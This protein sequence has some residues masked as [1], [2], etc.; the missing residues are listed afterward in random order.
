[1]NLRQLEVYYAIMRCRTLTDA[2]R[3]LNVSQPA[4]SKTLSHAE[5]QLGFK[6]FERVKGRLYPTL[7][8][9]T[10]MPEAERIFREL[11]T[12]RQ[13]S[14]DL[15][16]G[17][18]GLVRVA[19]TSSLGLTIMPDAIAAFRRDHPNVK[20]V[21]HVLPAMR[22][23]ELILS[24]KIDIGITM[25][26]VR[27][28]TARIERRGSVEMVCI[29]PAG[30]PLSALER[31]EPANL[32]GQSFVCFPAGEHFRERIDETLKS[33]GIV[34][35]FDLEVGYSIAAY[36]LVQRGMG[37]ALVDG[38]LVTMPLPG[39]VWRPFRPLIRAEVHVVTASRMPRSSYANRFR[40]YL[41]REIERAVGDA[42]T[43]MKADR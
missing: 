18:A 17:Q 16:S 9:E 2:A 10:L 8:A 11:S 32:D 26:P 30:H 3:M 1:M 33:A 20:I 12:F 14:Q 36:P 15:R 41:D 5:D 13:L 24:Q 28:P 39:T 31:V 34:A 38:I 21:S 7:E 29:M 4:V 27:T 6:L 42:R 22:I 35:R 43:L 23:A 25:S 19:A 37:V 40:A